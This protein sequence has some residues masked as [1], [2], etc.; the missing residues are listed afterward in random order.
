M[1]S[2]LLTSSTRWW[3]NIACAYRDGIVG[4]EY[5]KP[6]EG[7]YGITALPLLTGR[8]AMLEP[9]RVKYIRE[10]NLSDMHNSLVTQ[11]GKQI[12]ILRGYRLKSIYAPSAG[13]RYDGL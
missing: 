1:T 4:N 2:G 8:E 10:G 3:L 7:Q 9:N 12:R 11:T 6:T 5:E 13:V